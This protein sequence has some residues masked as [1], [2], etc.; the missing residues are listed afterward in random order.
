MA[1]LCCAPVSSDETAINKLMESIKK[2]FVTTDMKD[3]QVQLLEKEISQK[4]RI[5]TRALE[6]EERQRRI[7]EIMYVKIESDIARRQ[8]RIPHKV[9]MYT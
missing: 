7:N 2:L 8:D 9:P 4:N 3:D 5:L 6:E 1:S